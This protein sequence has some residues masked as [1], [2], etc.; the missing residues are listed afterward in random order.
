MG[1]KFER[2]G[3]CVYTELIHF[4]VQQKLTQNCKT[5]IL[6]FKKKMKY[7][8]CDRLKENKLLWQTPG[9]RKD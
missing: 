7:T 9:S 6:L 8:H 3:I 2:V 4:T 5:T 1:G